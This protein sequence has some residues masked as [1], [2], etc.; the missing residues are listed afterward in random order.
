M[1]WVGILLCE[2][3]L[4]SVS[5]ATISIKGLSKLH[6]TLWSPTCVRKSK[7]IIVHVRILTMPIFIRGSTA[8][9]LVVAMDV[10]VSIQYLS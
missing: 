7:C 9:G 4:C 10:K 2:Q 3:A 8:S 5:V 6:P 1:H